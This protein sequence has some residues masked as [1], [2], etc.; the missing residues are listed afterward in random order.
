LG[1]N[2]VIGVSSWQVDIYT[3]GYSVKAYNEQK[4]MVGFVV[5]EGHMKNAFPLLRELPA[6]L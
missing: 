5:T 3:Q 2:T 4:E 1:R 6:N